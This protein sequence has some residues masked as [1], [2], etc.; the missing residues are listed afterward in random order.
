MYVCRGV[1]EWAGLDRQMMVHSEAKRR[2]FN[3]GVHV[4][5]YFFPVC[6]R[7]RALFV[8]SSRRDCCFVV[9][10]SRA[11]F[12]SLAGGCHGVDGFLLSGVRDIRADG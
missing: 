1:S 5:D 10:Q 6:R 2:I 11:R 4:L 3:I 12:V 9:Q 7:D 8:M